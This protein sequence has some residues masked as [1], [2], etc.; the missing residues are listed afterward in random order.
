MT[1]VTDC[2]AQ[3]VRSK[4]WFRQ[5]RRD[6]RSAIDELPIDDV[7][8]MGYDELRGRISRVIFERD[9]VAAGTNSVLVSG[10]L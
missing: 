3:L 2:V 6:I 1:S 9:A 7:L 4:N 10:L 5:D 8:R